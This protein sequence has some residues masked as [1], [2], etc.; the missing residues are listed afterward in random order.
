MDRAVTYTPDTIGTP[1]KTLSLIISPFISAVPTNPALIQVD[2]DMLLEYVGQRQQQQRQQTL[3]ITEQ[4]PVLSI[5]QWLGPL[6]PPPPYTEVGVKEETES[7]SRRVETRT[8]GLQSRE[9]RWVHLYQTDRQRPVDLRRWPPPNT[10]DHQ[11]IRGR[12]RPLQP[13]HDH[14][15]ACNRHYGERRGGEDQKR[16]V[17][18]PLRSERG[19]SSTSTRPEKQPQQGE[20]LQQL[21]DYVHALAIRP[22]VVQNV[23]EEMQHYIG[24]LMK[25]FSAFLQYIKTAIIFPSVFK[26]FNS[27]CYLYF[28]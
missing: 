16:R 26:L 28:V 2:P 5:K 6:T 10:L 3:N 21:K 4:N 12:N 1:G 25:W 27:S 23:L 19:S 18:T 13:I 9:N 8:H 11:F 15:L 20:E 14:Q 17:L 24:K 22:G 7:A